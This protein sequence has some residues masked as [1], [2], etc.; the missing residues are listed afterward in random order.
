MDP[1]VV[2]K[3]GFIKEE[4][5]DT[6]EE[7]PSQI[8]DY[9]SFQRLSEYC[10]SCLHFL[11]SCFLVL[12]ACILGLLALSDSEQRVFFA[13]AWIFFHNLKQ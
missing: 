5:E 1:L 8:F 2:G 10:F 12:A 11:Q 4:E 6:T 9:V 13:A 7:E 3:P